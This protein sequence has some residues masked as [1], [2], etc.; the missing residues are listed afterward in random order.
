VA[1]AEEAREWASWKEEQVRLRVKVR[2][3][4]LKGS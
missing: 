1:A 3:R 2:V 4:V